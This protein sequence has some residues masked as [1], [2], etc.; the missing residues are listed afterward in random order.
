M[1]MNA[2]LAAKLKMDMDQK[3][4]PNFKL[5][6]FYVPNDIGPTWR[7]RS[8][9]DSTYP[10]IPA[11]E[12]IVSLEVI[13]AQA[14]GFPLIIGSGVRS[15]EHNRAVDGS[16]N[17]GHMKGAGADISIRRADDG[18]WMNNIE[19]GRFIKDLYRAGRLEFLA[20]SYLIVGKTGTRV[21]IGVDREVRRSTIWGAGYEKVA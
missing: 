19:L 2:A 15:V 8:G 20:Y 16:S 21:H 17:S 13:R 14:G 9:G 11:P 12:L 6:E 4:S 10:P 18:R 1:S 3:M 5:G 7:T